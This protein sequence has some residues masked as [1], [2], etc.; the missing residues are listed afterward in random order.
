MN[1]LV[2]DADD[3]LR[4]AGAGNSGGSGDSPQRVF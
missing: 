1:E 2:L 4:V 3:G